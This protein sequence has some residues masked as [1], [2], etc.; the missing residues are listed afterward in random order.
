M[1]CLR[2]WLCRGRSPMHYV[3]VDAEWPHNV[4]AYETRR[5][6][7]ADYH[8]EAGPS[9][10]LTPLEIQMLSFSSDLEWFAVCVV[11]CSLELP[12]GPPLDAVAPPNGKPK[13]SH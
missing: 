9:V 6:L 12:Q 8:Y 4:H 5:R 1:D 3:Y 13:A 7:Q 2:V 10:S 11:D